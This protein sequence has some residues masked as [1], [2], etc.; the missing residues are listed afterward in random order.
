[1]SEERNELLTGKSIRS[2]RN[3]KGWSQTK[4]AE[5]S[6]IQNTLISAYETGRKEPGVH[7]LATLARA[8]EVPM[9]Q[10]YYGDENVAFLTRE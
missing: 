8:L 9:E 1:M 10:L 5:V 6:G 7:T 3:D 2:A 4:L